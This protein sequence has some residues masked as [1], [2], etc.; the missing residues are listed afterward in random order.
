MPQGS[1]FSPL[2][3]LVYVD[4][5]W[6]NI[7]TSII[8][9]AND[10]IMYRKITN[11]NDKEKLQ[12]DLDTL[13]EWAVENGIKINPRKSKAIRFTRTRVKTPLGYFLGGQKIP[14]RAV[15]NTWE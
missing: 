3:F 5:I 13:G 12:K 9:F 14:K 4:D 7:D 2:L 1:V 11:K 15:L 10:C 6:R 8:L